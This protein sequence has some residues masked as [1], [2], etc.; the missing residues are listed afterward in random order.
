MALKNKTGISNLQDQYTKPLNNTEPQEKESEQEKKEDQSIEKEK[1]QGK[2]QNTPKGKVGRPKTKD[3]KKT[4]KNINV[5]IPRTLLEK[6]EEIKIVHGNNLTEYITKLI[7][8]DMDTNY[9]KYKEL[10]DSLKNI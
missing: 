1:K 7:K 6:W 2:S 4:C 9:K 3:I 10:T 8:K 5:A